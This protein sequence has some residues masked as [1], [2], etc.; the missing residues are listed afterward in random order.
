M[1]SLVVSCVVRS[2]RSK[3]G[4]WRER[5][6][7]CSVEKRRR[8]GRQ[9]AFGRLTQQAEAVGADGVDLKLL[10]G[11]LLQLMAAPHA[12]GVVRAEVVEA[13]VGV[14]RVAED[15]RRSIVRPE[16]TCVGDVALV[17]AQRLQRAVVLQAGEL[18]CRAERRLEL[19]G[20]MKEERVGIMGVAANVSARAG[21]LWGGEL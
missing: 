6:C 17:T 15:E 13:A 19:C 12:K 2:D 10:R 14:R 8:R 1:T 18:T 3:A 11:D 9:Q 20:G 21:C 5:V 16:L 7:I 4:R